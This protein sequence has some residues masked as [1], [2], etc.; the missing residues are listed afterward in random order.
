[1]NIIPPSGF[2]SLRKALEIL[3]QCMY[4]GIPATKAIQAYRND[5]AHVVDGKQVTAAVKVLRQGIRQGELTLFAIFSSRDTPMRLYNKALIEAALFP[6]NSTVLTFVYCERHSLAPFGLSWSDL[7]ELSRDPLC[8]DE[9]GFGRW[10]KS[11]ERKKEWPCHQADVESRKVPGRPSLIDEVIEAI[12]ELSAKGE[13]TPSTPNKVVQSL[14]QS[15]HPSLRKVS[16]ET[17]RRARNQISS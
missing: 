16:E 6:P 10:L 11:Q 1:M 15:A 3:I 17:V 2:L 8:L 4:G 13:L 12:E 9:K 7:K 14:V 5:G